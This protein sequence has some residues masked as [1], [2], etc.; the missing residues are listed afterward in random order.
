MKKSR[1]VTISLICIKRMY[2]TIEIEK[3]IK[4]IAVEKL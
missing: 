4:E 3:S 1:K 2:H